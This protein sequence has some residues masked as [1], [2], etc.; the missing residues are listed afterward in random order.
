MDFNNLEDILDYIDDNLGG[1][2]T[3][4]I[5]EQFEKNETCINLI[6]KFCIENCDNKIINGIELI[7]EICKL[8]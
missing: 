7:K 4:L 5:R 6:T 2:Y 1:K 3:N 8:K